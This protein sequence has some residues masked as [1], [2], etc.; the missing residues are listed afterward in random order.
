MIELERGCG[1]FKV[2]ESYT[3]QDYEKDEHLPRMPMN[4][5]QQSIHIACQTGIRLLFLW[6]LDGVS[7]SMSACMCSFSEM[8]G[9]GLYL[10]SSTSRASVLHV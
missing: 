2:V 4:A 3:L 10:H 7:V 8:A 1:D 5:G 9:I 6:S